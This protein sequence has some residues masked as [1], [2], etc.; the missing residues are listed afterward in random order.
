M[1]CSAKPGD[2]FYY[3]CIRSMKKNSS[4]ERR[5]NMSAMPIAPSKKV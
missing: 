4:L 1:Q 5:I 3:K 2:A